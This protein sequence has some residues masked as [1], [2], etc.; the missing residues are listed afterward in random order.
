M[1]TRDLPFLTTPG[2]TSWALALAVAASAASYW[3]LRR[4]RAS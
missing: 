3:L 1:N 2:G 4:M